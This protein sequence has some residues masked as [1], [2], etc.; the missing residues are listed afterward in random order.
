MG[1]GR[2]LVRGALL[3]LLLGVMLGLPSSASA[4]S[5]FTVAGGGALDHP[6]FRQ[7]PLPAT[8]VGTPFATAVASLPDS[9]FLVALDDNVLRVRPDGRLRSMIRRFAFP[10]TR[11]G[12]VAVDRSGAVLVTSD[13][14]LLRIEP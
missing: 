10:G 4:R 1:L 2:T 7:R 13:S 8:L 11:I 14:G 9:G 5:I 3:P 6:G 12:G